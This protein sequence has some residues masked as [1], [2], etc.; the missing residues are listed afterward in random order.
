MIDRSGHAGQYRIAKVVKFALLLDVLNLVV[1][2]RRLQLRVPVHQT[3]A[4]ENQ[5][6]LEHLEEGGADGAGAHRIEREAHA[7][8]IATAPQFAEL[9]EDALLV[10]VLPLPDALDQ[11]LAAEIVAGLLFL[12]AQAAFDH[13]LRGDAGVIGARHP[14]GIVTLHAPPAHEHV[15]QGV[16]EGVAQVQR[17]VT[18]GGGMT[19]Q[20]GSRLA[21]GRAW[22]KPRSFQKRS[23]RCCAS[24]GS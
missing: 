11:F 3:F 2:H 9:A 5:A 22:K 7:L 17:P 19:M 23:Q 13:G 4:A 12:V 24:R 10:L 14:Q 21:S 15:L 8:P 1:G 18:L 20:N 16:I 6:I